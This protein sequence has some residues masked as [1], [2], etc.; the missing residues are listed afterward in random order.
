MM[1]KKRFR[2]GNVF[3]LTNKNSFL[4]KTLASYNIHKDSTLFLVLR[5]ELQVTVQTFTGKIITLQMKSSNTIGNVKVE[6]QIR[7]GIQPYDQML[8]IAGKQLEDA[9][10]LKDYNISN[11][12]MLTCNLNIPGFRLQIS[13]KTE[14]GKVINLDVWIFD[15]IHTIKAKIQDKEDIAVDHQRLL[16]GSKQLEDH[17]T[18][19]TTLSLRSLSSSWWY[20]I[21]TL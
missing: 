7:E 20:P 10:T 6:I 14:T 21:T 8:L 12:S 3:R 4:C 17:R 11:E 13:V 1:P 9:L 5:G 16:F 15:K 18:I 2:I 19:D